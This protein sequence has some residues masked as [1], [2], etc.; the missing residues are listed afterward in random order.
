MSDTSL[1]V[2][3][4]EFSAL[5]TT[6]GVVV[7][8]LGALGMFLL[9]VLGHAELSLVPLGFWLVGSLACVPGIAAGI[10]TPLVLVFGI[11]VL[12][13]TAGVVVDTLRRRARQRHSSVWFWSHEGS[14]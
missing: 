11:G 3:L 5:I 8:L 14:W 4:N 10:V 6:V 7:G 13:I 9:F 1:L 2:S 12:A